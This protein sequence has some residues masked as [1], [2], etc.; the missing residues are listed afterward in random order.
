MLAK[1]NPFA[2]AALRS[3]I[4]PSLLS[5]SAPPSAWAAE[6]THV[7][8]ADVVETQDEL[9]LMMDLPGHDPKSLQVK[10]E[11]DTLSVRSERRQNHEERKRRSTQPRPIT[12]GAAEKRFI[13]ATPGGQFHGHFAAA[14][15]TARTERVSGAF[16]CSCQKRASVR[17]C[18]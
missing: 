3:F 16:R 15:I 11:N 7:P 12:P 17:T 5:D 6:N 10:L 13:P 4:S 14:V 2:D 9:K 18:R 8:V 1:W